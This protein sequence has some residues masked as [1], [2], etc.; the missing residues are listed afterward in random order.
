MDTESELTQ[1]FPCRAN[2]AGT[3]R[4]LEKL[5][6][7]YGYPH[8]INSD[9]GHILMVMICSTGQNT[10]TLNGSFIPY[11]QQASGLIGK[12]KF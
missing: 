8:Q 11:N 6:T 3:I 9:Q 10:M 4:G 2:W 7:T 12:M 1:A 5:S